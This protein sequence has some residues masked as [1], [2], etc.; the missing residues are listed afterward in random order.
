M[1]LH[2]DGSICREESPC[3]RTHTEPRA[4]PFRCAGCGK[5]P[6]QLPCYLA[7]LVGEDGTPDPT[8]PDADAYVWANEGTLNRSTG[9]FLCDDCYIA[10]GMPTAPGGW[11]VPDHVGGKP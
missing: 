10:A 2:P 3:I 4:R 7:M 5:T 1:R 9:L 11:T 8:Y 6:D